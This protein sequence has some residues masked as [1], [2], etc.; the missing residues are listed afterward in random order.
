MQAVE[1]ALAEGG[2]AAPRGRLRRPRHDRR[3]ERDHRGQ[4][5]AHRLRDDRRLPRPARDRPPDAPDPLRPA[6]R[7]AAAARARATAPSAS[8]SGSGQA[9]EVAHAARRRAPCARPRALLEREEVESV[10]V[11]LLHSYVNPRARAAGRRDPRRG[12]ARGSRSR[13]RRRSRRSSASTCAPSTTVINAVHPAG[14]RALPRADRGS[15]WPRPGSHGE[16]AG[17]AV[18]RRRLRLRGRREQAR[19]H[20]RVGPGGRRDRRRV[21]RARRSAVPDILSFDMG[22][23]TAKV[24]LIRDGQPSVTKDYEVGGHAAAGHRRPVARPA[25]RSGRR[26]S[27][28]SRSAPAAARSPGSTRAACSASARRARA[29]TPAPSATGA[30]ATSRR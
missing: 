16:A 26:S 2:V 8:P 22:G 30:A 27:T 24:G 28:W 23:T 17:D 10:A 1:R 11:C 4:D 5:R 19:L 29:P 18:E 20:G 9:G 13:S 14:R 7:E 3:H 6:V 25:T 15:G 21:P 12:A